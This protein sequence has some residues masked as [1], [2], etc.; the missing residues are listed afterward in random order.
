M[1]YSYLASFL[2]MLFALRLTLFLNLI[3]FLD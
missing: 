2:K 1:D 3:D